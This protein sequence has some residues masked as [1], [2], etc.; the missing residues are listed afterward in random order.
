[1]LTATADYTHHDDAELAARVRAGTV[2]AFGPLYERHVGAATRRART[3]ARCRAEADALVSDG[4]TRMLEVLLA[5]GGP[6]E[7]VRAYLLT[8]ITR[9]AYAR[10]RQEQREQP[11]EDPPVDRAVRTGQMS[12][13]DSVLEGALDKALAVRAFECLS[14]TAQ[15]VL[16][17]TEVLAMSPAGA[18][19]LLKVGANAVSARAH[20]ARDDL[21]IAFLAAH[22]DR[23]RCAPR[24]ASTVDRLSRWTRRAVC[25]GRRGVEQHL[26]GCLS[27]R[28]LA[29][30]LVA[31]NAT[32][33][34]RHPRASN[35]SLEADAVA[36]ERISTDED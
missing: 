36:A 11:M 7:S 10:S 33:P 28:S 35:S 34:P 15:Q 30:E 19:P 12:F 29:A 31:V 25:H 18:A 21:R 1:M 27:C 17:Y 5:G 22:V 20:R 14:P 13:Q 3:L 23:T 9:L 32:L 4:F 6:T 8:T 24:C 16:W 26:G 2:A